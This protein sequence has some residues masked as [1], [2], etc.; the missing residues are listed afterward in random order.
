MLLLQRRCRPRRRYCPSPFPLPYCPLPPF[1][2]P[3]YSHHA[4]GLVLGFGDPTTTT[5]STTIAAAWHT[6]VRGVQTPLPPEWCTAPLNSTTVQVP[7]EGRSAVTACEFGSVMAAPSISR[8]SRACLSGADLDGLQHLYPDCSRPH[9]GPPICIEA[10]LHPYV[11]H[12]AAPCVTGCRTYAHTTTAPLHPRRASVVQLQVSQS[13][14]PRDHT[15]APVHV[16]LPCG[17]RGGWSNPSR[18]V[19]P[20]T[21]RLLRAPVRQGAPQGCRGQPC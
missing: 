14:A 17:R 11:L 21:R 7:S 10:R 3:Y 9:H 18:I 4:I 15:G 20:P 19:R 12:A 1:T 16:G 6:N 13:A 5:T 8:R 2:T